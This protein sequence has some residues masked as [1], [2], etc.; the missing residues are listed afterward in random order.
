MQVFLLCWGP[1]QAQLIKVNTINAYTQ[2]QKML[3]SGWFGP[4][5]IQSSSN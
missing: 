1:S 5:L 4:K 2:V 3:L